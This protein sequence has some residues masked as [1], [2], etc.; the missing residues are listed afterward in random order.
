M[1]GG[2]PVLGEAVTGLQIGLSRIPVGVGSMF[3]QQKINTPNFGAGLGCGGLG[4]G[5]SYGI[6][7]ALNQ[8]A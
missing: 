1:P 8:I 3:S 7:I 5:Y 4:I 2:I 6:G